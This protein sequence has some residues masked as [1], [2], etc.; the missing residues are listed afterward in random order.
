MSCHACIRECYSIGIQQAHLGTALPAT[1]GEFLVVEEMDLE[2]FLDAQV[3]GAPTEL[4]SIASSAR[5]PLET[6]N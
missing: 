4:V 2:T 5:V 3:Q 1:G 6:F